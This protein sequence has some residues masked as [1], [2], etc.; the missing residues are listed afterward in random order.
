MKFT[1]KLKLWL[2]VIAWCGIIF[3]FSAMEINK[4]QEFYWW[5]FVV[6]KTIHVIEYAVLYWLF[7]QAI[8]KQ[9]NNKK[10]ILAIISFI[11]SLTYALS[12]EWHQTFIPG[13]HGTL[14][15]IGFDWLGML[16]SWLYI[17]KKI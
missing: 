14:R 7:Y 1:E 11:F 5:D 16:L 3:S 8:S 9:Q 13:R 15:D 6:K 2:P 17:R 4:T 12:D 10:G